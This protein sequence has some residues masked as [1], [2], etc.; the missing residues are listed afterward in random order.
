MTEITITLNASQETPEAALVV[1]C[2]EAA[3]KDKGSGVARLAIPI[4][5]RVVAAVKE[6]AGKS[7]DVSLDDTSSDLNGVS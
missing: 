4:Q 5:D 1:E 3:I 2:L 6:L 7:P